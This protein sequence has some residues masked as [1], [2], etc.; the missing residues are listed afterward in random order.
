VLH[1]NDQIIHYHNKIKAMWN[2][3][4]SET[5]R[6]NTKYDKANVYNTDKEY[7]KSV[8]VEKL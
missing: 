8:N 6:N 3:I 1:A 7:S 4:K 5:R 2:I